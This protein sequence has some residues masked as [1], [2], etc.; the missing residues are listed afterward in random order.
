LV[1]HY[2][3]PNSDNLG[4]YKPTPHNRQRI[5]PLTAINVVTTAVSQS[6]DL[7]ST[8][9]TIMDTVVEVVGVDAVGIGL[10]DEA[11]GELVLQARRGWSNGLA[12][13]PKRIVLDHDLVGVVVRDNTVVVYDDLSRAAECPTSIFIDSSVSSLALIPMHAR[14]SV[15]GILIVAGYVPYHFTNEDMMVLQ[16]IADQSGVALDNARLFEY[17]KEQSSRLSAVL[18]SSGDAIIATNSYG[19]INLVN[20]AAEQLFSFRAHEVLGLP[21][22]HAPLPPELRE[23]LQRAIRNNGKRGKTVFEVISDDGHTLSI[24]VS[25]VYSHPVLESD[26]KAEGWVVV[27]QNVTHLRHT[28]YLRTDFIHT[29]AHDLRNPLGVTLGALVMLENDI[30]DVSDMHKE[31]ISIG[32]QGVNRM[33]D[34][35]NDLL[36]LEDVESS[37]SFKHSEMDVRELIERGLVDMQPAFKERTQAFEVEIPNTLPPMVGDMRWLHRA[38]FNLLNNANQYTPEG[39]Q[40][41]LRVYVRDDDLYIEVQDD[42][43]GVQPEHQPHLFDRFFRIPVDNKQ[44]NR[45][46]GLG[47]AIV[48]RVAERHGGRAFVQSQP[49]KGSTFGMVLPLAGVRLDI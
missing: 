10:V 44:K 12:A 8:L 38:L 41:T 48:K 43:P 18:H 23:G 27:V 24:S 36:D 15:V 33:Q 20:A 32:I 14:G 42:G 5:E 26:R 22:S 39:G 49:G 46:S 17:S 45:G 35:I 19:Y 11:A 31:V 21:L 2:P 47:L 6:A 3:E 37:V 16:A 34:L 30:G 40:I 1:N 7:V 25:P 29:A 4:R 13:Q 9:R 28:E